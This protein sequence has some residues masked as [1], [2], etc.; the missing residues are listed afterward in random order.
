[1]AGAEFNLASADNRWTG[2]TFL[3]HSFNPGGSGN[4][5]VMAANLT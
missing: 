5:S 3:H 2:K 4:S 1:V